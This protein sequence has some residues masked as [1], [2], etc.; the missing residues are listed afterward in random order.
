M[1]LTHH[2]RLDEAEPQWAGLAARHPDLR[3]SIDLQRRLL[4][5]V[6]DGLARLDPAR[7]A[8]VAPT[9]AAAAAYLRDGV[10]ALRGGPIAVPVEVLA[11]GLDRCCR[12]L[13]EGGA[14]AV[15]EHLLETFEAGRLS[16]ASLLEA[17]FTR[18]DR[19]IALGAS[20]MGLSP[21]LV[22]LVAELATAPFAYALQST[23]FA[24]GETTAVGPALRAWNRG[25]CPACGSWPALIEQVGGH[26]FL[27]CSFCAAAWELQSRRCPYCDGAGPDCPAIVA[28]AARPPQHL[29]GCPAC[30][31]YTKVLDAEA[32]APFPLVAV[33]DLASVDLDRDAAD[34]GYRRP[35]LLHLGEATTGESRPCEQGRAGPA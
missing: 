4:G 18:N 9:P 10:P 17:S 30:G 31:G 6:L 32:P 26:R 1:A 28:D 8:A 15:A 24:A 13:A 20:Q 7:T 23:L 16:R 2:S 5:E 35:P 25:H 29:E 12:H 3:P 34:R 21:D 22:W 14:G 33:E 27:R 11:P 19:A